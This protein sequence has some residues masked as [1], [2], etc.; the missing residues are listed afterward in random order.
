MKKIISVLLI[1]ASL[2]SCTL[3]STSAGD[4][5]VSDEARFPFEDI[6]D[7]GW[8]VQ[9]LVFCYVNDVVNGMNEYTFA[10]NASLTRAQF[11]TMLAKIEKIDTEL[12]ETSR[13]TDV[14][15]GHW[16]YGAVSWAY[17]TGV[18]AGTSAQSFSPNAVVTRETA[19]RIMWLYMK[20]K[21]TFDIVEDVL[22]RYDDSATISSWAREG[23]MYAVESGLIT[24]MTDTTLSPK[25]NLTRA[26]AVRI[27]SVFMQEYLYGECKHR[28]YEPTCTT[29]AWCL[30]CGM[31]KTMPAGH[32]IDTYDCVTGGKCHICKEQISPSKYLHD[33]APANCGKPRTCKR[34]GVTRGEPTGNHDWWA[35][36]CTNPK[37][38]KICY[39]TE[40]KALGHSTDNGYCTK[41]KKHTF[42]SDFNKTVYFIKTKGTYDA[43]SGLYVLYYNITKSELFLVYDPASDM[44]VLQYNLWYHT[45]R[46]IESI[47]L[48]YTRDREDPMLYYYD[49]VGT[50]LVFVGHY[51]LDVSEYT[52]TTKWEFDGYEGRYDYEYDHY[53]ADYALHQMLVQTDWWIK[54]LYGGSIRDF[55]FTSFTYQ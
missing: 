55:G 23:M 9:D 11:V 15:P 22:E 21:Y 33:F 38:C 4:P 29:S 37:M 2:L 1:A 31:V 48:V 27:L 35:A 28:L 42:T 8:Y 12:Y 44:L 6:S 54:D 10:P 17:E 32:I 20:D 45:Q 52:D 39:K 36:T 49:Y 14:K 46:D 34:C 7:K 24:G 19:A 47:A 25:T 50:Q 13:F 51:L 53:Y 40:G 41:C 3:F 43:E 18:V 16:Y 26:Q 5:V 30:K